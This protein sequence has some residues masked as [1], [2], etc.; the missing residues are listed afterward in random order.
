MKLNKNIANIS[1]MRNIVDDDYVDASLTDRIS[2][3][4]DITAEL[5][6]LTKK[7]E[8]SAKSRLQRDV[9]NLTKTQR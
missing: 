1:S 2:M 4:W 6:S 5:W 3:V 8:M 7:G 9:A